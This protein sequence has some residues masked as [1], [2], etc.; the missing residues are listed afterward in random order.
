MQAFFMQS[1]RGLRLARRAV[2]VI[3]FAAPASLLFTMPAHAQAGRGDPPGG[4]SAVCTVQ[5]SEALGPAVDAAKPLVAICQSQGLLLGYADS[6]QV[7]S[8]NGLQAVLVDVHRGAQRRVL[9]VSLQ[10]DGRPLVE[11]ISGQLAMNA[12]RGPL[13]GLEGLQIDVGSFVRDG[14]VAVRGRPEE[15][16]GAVKAGR[17]NLGQQIAELRASRGGRPAQN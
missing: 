3:L 17:I 12:G 16:G 11:D 13:S 15:N 4:T 10:N 5:T 9:L 1:A 8:H 2:G 7:Y 6:F 14:S